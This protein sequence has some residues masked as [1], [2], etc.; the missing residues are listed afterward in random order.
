M[1][2]LDAMP[3]VMN[4]ATYALSEIDYVEPHV[5]ASKCIAYPQLFD[6]LKA[7]WSTPCFSYSVLVSSILIN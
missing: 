2:Y 1:R 3:D 5:N 6:E 4:Y 7:L